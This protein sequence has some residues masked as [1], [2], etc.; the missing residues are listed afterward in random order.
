[1]RA[2]STVAR[3]DRAK[4]GATS[5]TCSDTRWC[6]QVKASPFTCLLFP[7][8]PPSH[9]SFPSPQVVADWVEVRYMPEEMGRVLSGTPNQTFRARPARSVEGRS[10][11]G[12]SGRRCGTK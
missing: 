11:G 8:A 10:S 9:V 4:L 7:P 3:R 12:R 1:M 5:N 2:Q 6:N